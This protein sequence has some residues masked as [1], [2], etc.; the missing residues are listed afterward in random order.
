[1]AGQ[2]MAGGIIRQ[3]QGGLSAGYD[4]DAEGG[5]YNAGM[6]GTFGEKAVC[7]LETLGHREIGVFVGRVLRLRRNTHC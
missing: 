7:L 2:Q 6:S 4:S 3:Q 1:M 5:N